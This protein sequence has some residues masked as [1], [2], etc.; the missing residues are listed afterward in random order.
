MIDDR[1]RTKL[2]RKIQI[3]Y[4]KI[5]YPWGPHLPGFPNVDLP[6]LSNLLILGVLIYRFF[7]M[8]TYPSSPT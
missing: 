8:W 6:K 2:R 5:K 7:Q 1:D 4:N 3:S